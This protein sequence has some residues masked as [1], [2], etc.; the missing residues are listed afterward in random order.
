MHQVGSAA[1]ILLA[2][3]FA[4]A[5]AAKIARGSKRTAAAFA[6]LGVPSPRVAARAVPFVEL[7]IAALLVVVPR[8]GGLAAL[9]ALAAFSFVLA[10]AVVSGLE[11]G[12]G[13]FGTTST[14]AISFVDLTRNAML[15]LLAA[16]ACVPPALV[17]PSLPAAV[18]VSAGSAVGLVVL[19]LCDLYRQVGAVFRVELAGEMR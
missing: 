19:A 2:A 18:V 15:A 1:A 17:R 11:V 8:A 3:V 9:A 5:G 7:A 14:E 10:H 6:A 13:C 12:C 16:A 4:W